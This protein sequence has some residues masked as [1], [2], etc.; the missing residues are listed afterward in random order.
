MYAIPKYAAVILLFVVLACG[1]SS[2]ITSSWRSSDKAT[3]TFKKVIVLGLIKESDR[4]I[5]EEMEQYLAQ[6]LRLRGQT[7]VCACDLYSPKEFDQLTEKQALEK[8]K[9]SGVDAVLTIVLLDKTRERYYIPGQSYYTPYGIY[10]NRFWGYSRTIYGRIYSQGYYTTDTKYFWESN[11]YDL[12]SGELLYSAQSQSF[13]PP[14]SAA[15]GKEYGRLIVDDL[16]SKRVIAFSSI[17]TKV[18]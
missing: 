1:S 11:L 5:R 7:A 8:L 16:V 12:E 4:T 2:R 9:D 15:M 17:P 13:D 10:Y 3:A 14:S 6:E 18:P